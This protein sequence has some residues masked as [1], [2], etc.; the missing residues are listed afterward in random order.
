MAYREVL[1]TWVLS[2]MIY[3]EKKCREVKGINLS[4]YTKLM[5]ALRDKIKG[6][7]RDYSKF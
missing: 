7:L 6:G 2:K 3:F 5:N 4:K 1:N